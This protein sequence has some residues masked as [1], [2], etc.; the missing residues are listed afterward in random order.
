MSPRITSFSTGFTVTPLGPGRGWGEGGG[1]RRKGIEQ[2]KNGWYTEK[3]TVRWK[4]GGLRFSD[5]TLMSRS[6]N[7]FGEPS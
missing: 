3:I 6:T 7:S 5:S 2:Y 4:R 1:G